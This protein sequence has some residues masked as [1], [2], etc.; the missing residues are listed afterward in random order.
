MKNHKFFTDFPD[1]VPSK[2]PNVEEI[3]IEEP[4]VIVKWDAEEECLYV[5]KTWSDFQDK[6][7][8]VEDLRYD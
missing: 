2:I 4:R 7:L 1:V 5:E 3:K 6:K 8:S